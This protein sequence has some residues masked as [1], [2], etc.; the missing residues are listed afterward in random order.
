MVFYS[1][2]KITTVV[3]IVLT[4]SGTVM[5]LLQG[6][7]IQGGTK[8]KGGHACSINTPLSVNVNLSLTVRKLESKEL[9]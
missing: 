7:C 6:V 2:F 1:V 9:Q 4:H 3:Q 5:C 8:E